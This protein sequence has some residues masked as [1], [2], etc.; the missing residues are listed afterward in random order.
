MMNKMN[1]FVNKKLAETEIINMGYIHERNSVVCP[2]C[3]ESMEFNGWN[4]HDGS[5]DISDEVYQCEHCEK[6]F[7]VDGDIQYI[8]NSYSRRMKDE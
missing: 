2:Y 1:S 3:Y 5:E 6:D 7:L 4:F 8:F